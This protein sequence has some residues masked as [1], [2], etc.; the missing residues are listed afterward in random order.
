LLPLIILVLQFFAPQVRGQTGPSPLDFLCT[1]ETGPITVGVPWSVT[2]TASGG[3]VPYSFSPAVLPSWLSQS[4][5][6]NSTTVSGTPPV[7]GPDPYSFTLA[8]QDSGSPIQT[9]NASFMG[10]ATSPPTITASPGTLS[11]TYEI[12]GSFPVAQTIQ[13]GS[14]NPAS[15][16]AVTASTGCGWLNLS[17]GNGNTTYTANAGVFTTGLTPGPYSCTITFSSLDGTATPA[18]V[19]ANLTVISQVTLTPSSDTTYEDVGFSGGSSA[20]IASG[21]QQ[22]YT[23]TIAGN[24]TPGETLVTTP[25]SSPTMAY[26]TGTPNAQGTFGYTITVT[27]ANQAIATSTFTDMVAPD[28]SVSPTTVTLPSGMVG[29]AYPATSLAVASGGLPSIPAPNSAYLWSGLP[30]FGLTLDPTTGAISGT[31]SSDGTQTFTVTVSDGLSSAT[32][33]VT[34]TINT[35]LPTVITAIPTGT[36]SFTY[37]IGGSVMPPLQSINVGSSNPASG[38]VVVGSLGSGCG[39]LVLNG[40]NGTTPYAGSVNVNTSGL[41][42]GPYSC[43]ITFSASA[44]GATPVTVLANLT[45]TSPTVITV[46][47][48]TLTFTYQISGSAPASQPILVGSTNPANGVVV[49]SSVNGTCGWLTLS[50]NG[51][52]PYTATAGVNTTGLTPS[53]SPYTCMITFSATGATSVTV[54]ASLTVITQPSITVSPATLSFTYQIGGAAPVPQSIQVSSTK[55]PPTGVAVTS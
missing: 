34:L 52:T 30:P 44:S 24:P 55:K 7:P 39:W 3:T 23:F 32:V 46:S 40:G 48:P 20:V 19:Q 37:Q 25:A 53:S 38:V 36:L 12:G 16:E 21:G 26:L 27:D 13:V 29:V 54:P 51:T 50:G 15:G 10:T 49:A 42:P 5:N 31:P 18:M 11:F 6:T 1:A 35:P 2:C 8:V 22:P 17:G 9:Q 45:V 14:M 47:P 43:M 41:T 4:T 33:N 28:V